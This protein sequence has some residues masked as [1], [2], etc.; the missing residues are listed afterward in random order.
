MPVTRRLRR[1][2]LIRRP[3][4]ITEIER[5][6]DAADVRERLWV[7]PSLPAVTS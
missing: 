3:G 1:S 2:P 4:I 6:I 5:R 7:V